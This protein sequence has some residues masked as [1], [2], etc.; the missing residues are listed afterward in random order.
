MIHDVQA[1]L[2][3]IQ[4][5]LASSPFNRRVGLAGMKA[6]LEPSLLVDS[7]CRVLTP[8]LGSRQRH[9]KCRKGFMGN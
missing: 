3:L 8:K 9:G 2:K 6:L 7:V 4:S 1:Y 5:A